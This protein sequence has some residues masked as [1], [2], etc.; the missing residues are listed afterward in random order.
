[1]HDLRISLVHLE[2]TLAALVDRFELLSAHTRLDLMLTLVE[3]IRFRKKNWKTFAIQQAASC[4]NGVGDGA[5]QVGLIYSKALVERLIHRTVVDITTQTMQ[6]HQQLQLRGIAL[7]NRIRASFDQATIQLALNDM[8]QERLAEAEQRL[9]K[10]PHLGQARS[11]M[12]IIVAVRRAMLLGRIYRWQGKF[13]T[14]IDQLSK[15]LAT[16]Q[17][18]ADLH[19]E[20]DLPDLCCDLADSLRDD[21]QFNDAEQLLLDEIKRHDPSN[22]PSSVLLSLAEALFAQR[23]FKEAELRCLDVSKCQWVSSMD[24]L[25]LS[26]IRAKLCHM[27]RSKRDAQ[28]YWSQALGAVDTF[29]R[30]N[31]HT[32]RIIILSMSKTLCP[33][34]DADYLNKSKQQ[35]QAL[36]KIEEPGSVSHWIAGM[37]EWENF[38]ESKIHSRF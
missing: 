30:T 35:L 15:A 26:I 33:I 24:K 34:E 5:A 29:P 31:G 32:T 18:R 25:R 21:G 28:S 19:F 3:A 1:M 7:D 2:H 4:V 14:S 22:I 13:S 9:L 8:Q 20:E 6:I 38:I 12:E 27:I 17:E 16:K 36:Q 11:S 23:R 37:K 10:L